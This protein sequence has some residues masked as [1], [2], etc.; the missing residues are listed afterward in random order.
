MTST[1]KILLACCALIV[2]LHVW[3]TIDPI[4]ENWG[5]HFFGFYNTIVPLIAL[6]IFLLFLIPAVQQRFLSWLA[7]FLRALSKLPLPIN[8]AIVAG[9]LY[10]GIRLFPAKLHLLGDGAILLRSATLGIDGPE[11]TQ[12]FRNQPLMFWI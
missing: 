5:V 3:G 7:T 1:A 8:F 12:S 10:A 11:I 9:I 2:L 6:G 4:H